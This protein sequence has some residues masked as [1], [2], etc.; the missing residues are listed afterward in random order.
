ML[1]KMA[2]KS[3]LID[4][5]IL[6]YAYS[7]GSVFHH[8]AEKFLDLILPEQQF[9]LSIQNLTEFYAI[10]TSP[11]RVPK[12]I[13]EKLAKE[14]IEFMVTGG[15]FRIITP[16]LV[17]PLTL[18]ELLKKNSVKAPEIFDLQLSAVMIDNNID[19][20]YTAD[21]KIFRRLGL[22]AINPLK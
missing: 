20:I 6:I 7:E 3:G 15:Y 9:F 16:S 17:T 21:P 22:N 14:K 10:V 12:P 5:N 1:T 4:S 13:S 11:K 2:Y 8:Q 19:T 18:I